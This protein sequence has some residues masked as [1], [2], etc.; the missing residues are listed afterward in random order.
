MALQGERYD[1]HVIVSAQ[2]AGPGAIVLLIKQVK[3]R[4]TDGQNRFL[5]GVENTLVFPVWRGNRI[6]MR[7]GYCRYGG[8]SKPPQR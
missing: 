4:S 5:V 3:C 6:S 1:S 2:A 7:T 8:N